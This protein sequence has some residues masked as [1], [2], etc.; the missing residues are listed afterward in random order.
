MKKIVKMI[1]VALAVVPSMISCLDMDIPPLNIITEEQIF[2]NE[3]GITAYMARMYNTL[4]MMDRRF[5]IRN[6]FDH[7]YV[8]ENIS[9]L[10]GEA[11]GRDQQSTHINGWW[12]YNPI[13]EINTFIETLPLYASHHS[14][15]KI[16][17]WLGEAHFLRAY[18]YQAMAQRYGGVPLVTRVLNYPDED[19][20]TFKI[21]RSSEEDT[22]LQ[23]EADYQYAID[24][25]KEK[26]VKGR[27]NRYSAAAYKAQAMIFAASVANFNEIEHFDSERGLRLCGIDKSRAA[28][29]YKS[30]YKAAKLVEGHYSLYRGDWVKGDKEAQYTNFHNIH[31]KVDNCEN[32]Y[33]REYRY[34]EKTHS[35]DALYGPQQQKQDGLAGG[36][37][38]VVEL[39]ELYEGVPKDEKGLLS[40]TNPDNTYIMYDNLMDPYKNA[41]P[42]L[43]A[44][45]IF[46]DD[47]YKNEKIEI[48]RGV[49]TKP[50]PEGGLTKFTERD[51][52]VK[53][54]GLNASLDNAL[55]MADKPQSQ[56]I[57]TKPD[58]TKM[59]CTG[60]SGVFNSFHQGSVTGYLLRKNMDSQLDREFVVQRR[61][62]SDWVDM[63]YAT[64]LLIRAEAAFELQQ[65]GETSEEGKSYMDDALA[66]I[67]DIRDRAGCEVMFNASTLTREELHNEFFREL[68]FENRLYW[69][70]VRWRTYHIKHNVNKRYHAAVPFYAG[71]IGKWFYDIK[72]DEIGKKFSFNPIKYYIPIPD[73]QINSNPNL[74][75]NIK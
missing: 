66:C 27:I 12:N 69:E 36:V 10:T 4:P 14:E 61:S 39:V 21:P 48:W 26:S 7:D 72:Y 40:F 43:R 73:N 42:R 37:A 58:G 44:T 47:V 31:Q 24:N 54:Q 53:Y 67:N 59:N 56:K 2:D 30:A 52:L 62:E 22:W 1:A 32:I 41:E 74:V 63:R 17:H 65:L 55:L 9:T 8:T 68:A 34:P 18:M 19:I 20:E 29:F 28:Y 60:R 16:K 6:G 23:I 15:D 64:V 75:Q 25:C 70:L 11:I 57:Y 33:V 51:Q 3:P 46:P 5:S 50:I 49:Y 71:T 38:P 13:R 45:V 35:W